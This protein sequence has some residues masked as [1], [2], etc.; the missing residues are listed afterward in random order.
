[1]LVDSFGLV[2]GESAVRRGDMSALICYCLSN[3]LILPLLAILKGIALHIRQK[4][5]GVG[6]GHLPWIRH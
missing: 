4:G 6:R 5:A 1:M 3:K 2:S